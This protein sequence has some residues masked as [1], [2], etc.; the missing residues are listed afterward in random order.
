MMK[1]AMDPSLR[2]DNVHIE[3]KVKG[4]ENIDY[5]QGALSAQQVQHSEE[6]VTLLWDFP[7]L[8]SGVMVGAVLP[9]QKTYDTL[10]S[11]MALRGNITFVVL[12]GLLIA[13]SIHHR[14]KFLFFESYLLAAAYG[15]SFD[16]LA[17]LAA[18]MNFYVAYMMTL[19]V[20]GGITC[21]YLLKIFPQE[22]PWV[23]GLLWISTWLI[24]TFAVIL[25]GYTGLIYTLELLVALFGLMRLSMND[26]IRNLLSAPA[27]A[28]GENT[29]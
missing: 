22:R 13:L 16:F 2:A 12:M 25:E 28:S 29:P 19:F 20:F 26:S 8:Q 15:F 7:S 1:Y 23:F 21:F 27:I 3:F 18:F 9:S 6:G 24:P 5:P 11:S 10:I 17:Y 14:R 4:G